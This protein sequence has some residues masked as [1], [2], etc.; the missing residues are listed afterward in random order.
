MNEQ[1]PAPDL[2]ETLTNLRMRRMACINLKE[3]ILSI[4]FDEPDQHPVQK[5]SLIFF[6]AR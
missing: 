4:G 6:P 3:D 2:S 5:N 1:G